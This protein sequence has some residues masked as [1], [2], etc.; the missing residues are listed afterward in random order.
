MLLLQKSKDA[1]QIFVNCTINEV[2]YDNFL[3]LFSGSHTGGSQAYSRFDTQRS[4]LTWLGGHMG[5]QESNQ[6]GS[7]ARQEP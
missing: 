2:E 1:I 6:S 7:C 4:C 5:C 3:L